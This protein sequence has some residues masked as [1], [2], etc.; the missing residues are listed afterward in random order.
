MTTKRTVT[1]TIGDNITVTIDEAI[2]LV[3]VEEICSMCKIRPSEGTGRC[4]DRDCRR[5]SNP[6][7]IQTIDEMRA[8]LHGGA[9]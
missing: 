1:V 6:P 2:P 4:E 9:S 5:I 3:P 8:R 7:V